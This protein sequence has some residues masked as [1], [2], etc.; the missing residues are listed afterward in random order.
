M[1]A[2]VRPDNTNITV[3]KHELKEWEKL[4]AAD[5]GGRKPGRTDIKRDAIIG[6]MWKLRILRQDTDD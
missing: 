6:I 2:G 5:N 3:L 4:F 1:S